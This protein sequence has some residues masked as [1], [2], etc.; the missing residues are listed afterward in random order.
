MHL[1][2]KAP[3]T[4]SVLLATGVL[5]VGISSFAIAGTGDNLREGVRNGTS[6]RETQVISNI[7]SSTGA[8]GGYST[9]QSNLS[10]SGGA[11]VY[12]CR[13]AAGGSAATPKPQNPCLRA[14]NLSTGHAFEF[15]ASK[16]TIGGLFTV[17]TGGDAFKPFT[18]NATGVATGLNADEVDGLDA[19]QIIAAARTRTALDADTLDGRD[20]TDL[21][22]RWV[23]VG[24]TGQIEAQSGGFTVVTAYP[25][26][27]PAG[28]SP[29]RH[30]V[31]IDAGEDLS[32]N[33]LSATIALQNQ[34][35]QGATAV[36]NGTVAGPDAN[37]EFS[38]EIATAKCLTPGLVA[39]APAGTASNNVFVVSPRNSDGSGTVPGERKRF[40]VSIT[41]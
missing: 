21:E 3:R 31:Y 28:T 18:T 2:T 32:D 23:L 26:G 16:G 38:G 19:A 12:G 17:G 7:A 9:R 6:T 27:D 25:Q 29:A 33:G 10:S 1:H 5:A 22:T 39:C 36:N 40:Y 11:A 24:L 30:N 34:V 41:G 4:R 35:D 15:Q 14:N 13:S 37:P 20:S 8:T